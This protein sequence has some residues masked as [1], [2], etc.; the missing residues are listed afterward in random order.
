MNGEYN[1]NIAPLGYDLVTAR[2]A[3]PDRRPGLRVNPRAAALVRRAFRLYSTGEFSDADIAAWLNERP[4]IQVLRLGQKPINKEMMRELLQNRSYTGRVPHTDTVYK[5]TLGQGKMS[6]RNRTE[7]FEGKHQGFIPDELFD[8]C[9]AV[10]QN[11]KRY[12]KTVGDMHTYILHD[13]VFCA[14]CIANMPHGLVHENC[15]RMRPYFHKQNHIAYYHCIAH[16]QGYKS[17]GQSVVQESEL[18]SQIIAILSN[19][20]I[21]A[22]YQEQIEQAVRNKIEN[23]AALERMQ[24]INK[25]IERIDFRW[26]MGRMEKDEYLEKRQQLEQEMESLRPI[27]YDNLIE[28]ADLVRNFRLYW[29]ECETVENPLEAKKQ[30][31]AKIV[32]RIFAYDDKVIAIVLH[33]DFALVVGENKI[34]PLEVRNAIQ[35][36]LQSGG[37]SVIHSQIG[38]DGSR[39]RVHY[40]LFLSLVSNYLVSARN[41][42]REFEQR[43][44]SR[45]LSIAR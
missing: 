26:D 42:A 39:P 38:D 36:T 27:D 10:R 35:S 31:I 43:M 7:W 6:R 44:K 8:E 11:L 33:G 29:S 15:G 22:D 41:R 34:A 37:T 12:R 20:P 23:A 14:R 24:E 25:I 19:L 17:C 5:K 18:N 16:I 32:D 1:G 28:A 30:L 3:T 9:Q 4:Y 21:P 2:T 40:I 45:K 13:R